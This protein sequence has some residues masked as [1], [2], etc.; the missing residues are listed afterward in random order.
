MEVLT[1]MCWLWD[2]ELFP[3]QHVKVSILHWKF[4]TGKFLLVPD[5]EDRKTLPVG[6]SVS[7][8][9]QSTEVKRAGLR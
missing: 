9:E 8:P 2:M 4:Y 1:V 3:G 5:L 6:V 7:L